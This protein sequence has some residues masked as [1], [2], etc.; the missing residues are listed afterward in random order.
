[1]DVDNVMLRNLLEQ[2]DDSFR[3][4]MDNP[5]SEQLND[6]YQQAKLALD[7]YLADMRKAIDKRC[8]DF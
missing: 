4:L 8:G 2:T 7:H 5:Q 3:R 6:E 1:M